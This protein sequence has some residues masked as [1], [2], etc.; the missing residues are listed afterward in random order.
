MAE[1]GLTIGSLVLFLS[2]IFDASVAY[3]QHNYSQ[4]QIDALKKRRG[5]TTAAYSAERDA[6]ESVR[7]VQ[8]KPIDLPGLPPYTGKMNF[9]FAMTCPNVAGGPSYTMRFEA[10]EDANSVVQW[11]ADSLRANRWQVTAKSSTVTARSAEANCIVNV[12]PGQSR[13]FKSAV[14]IIYKQWK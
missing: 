10:Q 11:Y 5:R 14:T 8:R 2:L 9:L 4:E 3:A 13:E 6:K 1:K 12:T 7:T